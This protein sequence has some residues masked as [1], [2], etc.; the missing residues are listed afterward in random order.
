MLIAG[1]FTVNLWLLSLFGV[2][3]GFVADLSL[4]AFSGKPVGR[5]INYKGL[6]V[7][8]AEPKDQKNGTG[9]GTPNRPVFGVLHLTDVFGIQS[10]ENKLF[11]RA[12]YLTVVP[13]LFNGKP[14]SEDPKSSFNATEFFGSHGP[15]VTDPIVSTALSYMREELGATKIGSL[16][17]CFGGRYA[18]RALGLPRGRAVNAAFAAHP[19]LL[20]DDEIKAI[21]EKDT[22]M[23]VKRRIEIEAAM[24]TTGQ[25]FTMAL[26]GGVPH[27]FAVHPNLDIPVEKAGK[28]DAF[29]QALKQ[30][31]IVVVTGSA[32]GM[33]LATSLSLLEQDAMVGMCDLNG[34]GLEKGFRGLEPELQSQVYIQA[35]EVTDRQAVRVFLEATK[36]RFGK[37][38]G[39]ANFAGTG[40][41]ELGTESV[42]ETSDEEFGY[43]M[44]LNVRGA[45]N[46]LAESLKS[47]LLSHGGSFVHVGS[48]FS[49]QGF[50]RGAVFAASKHASLGMVRSAAKEVGDRARVNC[51]LPGAIDTPMRRANLERVSDFPAPT[52]VGT[53]QEVADVTVFLL[54]EKSTFVNGAAWGVDGGAGL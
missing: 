42:W 13:D 2:A 1:L 49:L 31:F 52:L 26:Y 3:D 28:E 46:V 9:I 16:G 37:V 6:E 43:I 18:F 35:V 8:V 50:L 30:Q 45:F 47:G 54:S 32:S 12:G 29:L 34:E 53:A 15:S 10:T 38:D 36:T 44:N 33:G 19:T 7:Y 27:G 21:T 23:Q 20:G 22:G 51:V 41:H 11:A 14:R 40:G 5:V 17:Y 24:G 39:V 4:L 48:M 25:P